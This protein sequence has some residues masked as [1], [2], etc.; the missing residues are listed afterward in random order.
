MEFLKKNAVL[1]GIVVALVVGGFTLLGVVNSVRDEGIGMETDLSA[2][3]LSN[4]D[5]LSKIVFKFK[6]SI[7]I[8]DRKSEQLDRILEN[9][10]KSRYEAGGVDPTSPDAVF[11]AIVEAYPDLQGLNLYDKIVDQLASGREEYSAD[12][13]KLLDRL[14]VYDRWRRKGL[15]K[16]TILANFFPSEN[17]EAR[18]GTTVVTGRAAREKMYQIVLIADAKRAYETGEMEALAP[19]PLPKRD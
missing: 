14:R 18:I 8:A 7:G 5:T 4:Q 11:S 3:Y 10:L 17:L 15:I 19:P 13:K 12:Q 1:L 16:S 6:E 2:Q 9:A